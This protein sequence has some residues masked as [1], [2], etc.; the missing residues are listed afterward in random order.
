MIADTQTESLERVS[1]RSTWN[2]S[3]PVRSIRGYDRSAGTAAGTLVVTGATA[4]GVS[5]FHSVRCV[6]QSQKYAAATD[7]ATMQIVLK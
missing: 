4:W 1:G 6:S 7:A 2:E 5:P 3:R